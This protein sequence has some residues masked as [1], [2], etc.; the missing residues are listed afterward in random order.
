M[1]VLSTWVY[2]YTCV[3]IHCAFTP[4]HSHIYNAMKP[5]NLMRFDS[6]WERGTGM[7]LL[8]DRNLS[9]TTEKVVAEYIWI[10]QSGMDIRSMGI[11]LDGPVDDISMLP[12]LNFDGAPRE[13]SEVILYPQAIFKDPFRRGANIL[14]LCN[15]Y[16]PAGE[17][18]VTNNRHAA[19]ETFGHPDVV[20]EEPWYR[21]E[22]EYTLLPRDVNW[23]IGLPVG[24]Y[25]GA[26]EPNY[27]GIGADIADSQYEACL[28]AGINIGGIEGGVMPGQWKFQVGPAVG[29]S[30]GDEL[31][32]A[33]Y[34]LARIT[35]SAGVVLA[36]DARLIQ[37]GDRNRAGS[38][39]NYSTESMRNDGGHEAIR[40]AIERIG[41]R[42]KEQIWAY[43]FTGCHETADI[44]NFLWGFVSRGADIGVGRDP[45]EAGNGSL[46]YSRPASNLDPYVVTSLIAETTI[47]WKPYYELALE[48]V[49]R[50]VER[51]WRA[52][53]G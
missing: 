31:W 9:N 17:P 23:L 20:A 18:I 22:Q 43:Y 1:L 47:L 16:T 3:Y 33:R 42:A 48:R 40:K 30:A 38:R 4:T 14:V 51:A 13:D 6:I 45:E 21:I 32:V 37:Q 24:G 12:R 35:E 28:Y 44:N 15:T 36:F 46:E 41:L 7:S 53:V 49:W 27:R 11:I 8:S 39:T 25:A 29:I 19:A 34:I 50:A 5:Y 2:I 52:V 26:Q 10:G